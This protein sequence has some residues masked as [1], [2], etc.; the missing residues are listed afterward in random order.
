MIDGEQVAE[1]RADIQHAV[2]NDGGR[3]ELLPGAEEGRLLDPPLVID[4]RQ[5]AVSRTDPGVAV[6]IRHGHG[7]AQGLAHAGRRPD[8]LA[9]GRVEAVQK[10]VATVQAER[11]LRTEH[12]RPRGAAADDILPE[13]F[14][15]LVFFDQGHESVLVL[16][17]NAAAG[18]DRR[19]VAKRDGLLLRQQIFRERPDKVI[20]TCTFRPGG[21]PRRGCRRRGRRRTRAIGR[22]H[23][24]RGPTGRRRLDGGRRPRLR[25][26]RTTRLG[27]RIGARRPSG[28][29]RLPL[30]P[31][32]SLGG[33]G[34]LLRLLP[35]GG[36]RKRRRRRLWRRRGP[37]GNTRRRWKGRTS[38]RFPWST[39]RALTR[40]TCRPARRLLRRL[41]SLH[42]R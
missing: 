17:E 40:R 15:L 16:E 1:F 11:I 13:Q 2:G 38:R 25:S 9:G 22:R 36:R 37:L 12:D 27:R 24:L 14:R 5:S 26:P 10:A 32:P 3:V 19:G 39:G 8:L 20:G 4:P 23:A 35:L 41:C 18:I 31:C 42:R 7:I 6:A 21:R 33:R 30:T 34:E 29:R 28:A